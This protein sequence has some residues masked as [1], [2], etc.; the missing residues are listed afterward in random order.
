MSRTALRLV[1]F[2][3]LAAIGLPACAAEGGDEDVNTPRTQGGSAVRRPAVAG[4]FYPGTAE[5]LAQAVDGYLSAA[6]ETGDG[7]VVAVISPHAGYVYS[8][9]VAAHAYSWLRGAGCETA[10]VVAPSHRYPFRGVSVYDGDGYETPLG[11]VPVDKELAESIMDEGAGIGFDPRAHAAEHSLEVQVPFLQRTLGDFSIVPIVMGS[12]SEGAARLLASR[13]TKAVAERGRERVVLVASTDLSHYH[14]YETA[15]ELDSRVVELVEAFDPEGLLE[16]LGSGRCEACGGGPAAA[17]MMAARQLGATRSLVTKYANSG[18]VTGDRGQVVGYMSAV[19]LADEETAPGPGRDTSGEV[20]GRRGSAGAGNERVE[21]TSS[22]GEAPPYEGL[23]SDER[24]E[25][26]RL[27]RAAISAALSGA[28]PPVSTLESAALDTECGA[29]VTLD[30]AGRLRG[31]I[32]YI[33]AVKPLR[34]TVAAMAVQAALHD[35][36]F[37]PV[38]ADELDELDIEISVLSPLV[39]VSDVGEIEVGRDGLIVRLGGASGLLLPQV[40]TDY[41]WDRTAFLENTCRK[42]GLPPD[43]WKRGD[44][45]ILRFTAEV[46]GETRD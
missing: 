26:L 9:G 41:G 6:A 5:A 20:K 19:L 27:A 40:A 33:Q 18:D 25:L 38:A 39:E 10:I 37:P 14:D 11:V 4:A 1:P 31:C 23:N 8:G 42:A 22:H 21:Q 17:V 43:S 2:L 29:F 7:R 15:V 30:K 24:D 36:R 16:A 3:M 32:G 46:F 35:P 34:E 13:I 12:Q 28:A 45:R 44:A